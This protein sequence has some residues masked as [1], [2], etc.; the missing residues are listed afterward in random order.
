MHQTLNVTALQSQVSSP[1]LPAL[2]PVALLL[3]VLRIASCRELDRSE[4]HE[5]DAPEKKL[6]VEVDHAAALGHEG[7]ALRLRRSSGGSSY[8]RAAASV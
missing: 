5:L 6:P 1:T 8:S 2:V 7:R 4:R 3:G